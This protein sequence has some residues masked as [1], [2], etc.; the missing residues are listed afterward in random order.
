MYGFGNSCDHGCQHNYGC[1]S[2]REL[3]FDRT[4]IYQKPSLHSTILDNIDSRGELIAIY[5]INGKTRETCF[6][7]KAIICG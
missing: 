3:K 6:D 4:Q 1:V 5:Q 2:R 7:Q